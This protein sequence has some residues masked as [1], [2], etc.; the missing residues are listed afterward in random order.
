MSAYQ[1]VQ[2]VMGRTALAAVLAAS[3]VPA[4][5]GPAWGA[6]T[7]SVSAEGAPVSPTADVPSAETLIAEGYT[8]FQNTPIYWKRASTK[9]NIFAV[10]PCAVP[11]NF[12]GAN[13]LQNKLIYDIY[14]GGSATAIGAKAFSQMSSVQ[15]VTIDAPVT[16]LGEEAFSYSAKLTTV[17]LPDTLKSIGANAFTRCTALTGIQVPDGVTTIGESAFS[18]MTALSSIALPSSVTSLGKAVF[19]GDQALRTVDLGATGLTELPASLFYQCKALNTVA[20]PPALRTVG[21]AAFY[22]CAALGTLTLP[23][24]VT[25]IDDSAFNGCEGLASLS[26]TAE[27]AFN[28]PPHLQ[29]LGAY[30]FSGCNAV[31]DVVLPASLES[32]GIGVF[33][34]GAGISAGAGTLGPTQVDLSATRLTEVPNFTFQGCQLTSV[35]LPETVT[36]VGDYAFMMCK[37][38]PRIDLP[39]G[40]S[41]IGVGAFK[42]C[43]K[44]GAI[45]LPAAVTSIGTEAFS[46]CAEL[47]KLTLPAALQTL[48]SGAFAGCSGLQSVQ[49]GDEPGVHGVGD[50]TAVAQLLGNV[51]AGVSA[52]VVA[53]SAHEAAEAAEGDGAACAVC[54][55]PLGT[56]TIK[57]EELLPASS[58]SA[59]KT[60]LAQVRG[61][62]TKVGCT[63]RKAFVLQEGLAQ[64]ATKYLK[65]GVVLDHAVD[66]VLSVPEAEGEL[67]LMLADGTFADDDALEMAPDGATAVLRTAYVGPVA[68]V[69]E[70]IDPDAYDDP[71]VPEPIVPE[72]EAPVAPVVPAPPA[73]PAAPAKPAAPTA[74]A[75]PAAPAPVS[76]AR[77]KVTLSATSKTYTGKALKPSV[78]VTYGGKTLKAGTDYTLT[79]ASNKAI[80]KA[81]ITVKGKGAYTGTVKKTFKIVP[82]KVAAKKAVSTKKKRA[83]VTWAKGAAAQK[84][85]GYQV[86][87]STS[88]KFTAKTT[89]TK[90]VKGRTKTSCTLTGLK[91]GKTYYVQV[92]AYKTVGGV[93]YVGAWSSKVL[94]VKVR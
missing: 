73:T 52:E 69:T 32:M 17:A 85:T 44:L 84:L 19:Y 53:P 75:K 27:H 46:G 31:R 89:K 9:L 57:A 90:T 43:A 15:S 56:V 6:E 40:V 50:A 10:S 91:S 37:V 59:V 93:K 30:A 65:S 16:S 11:D 4:G 62:A 36:A 18:Q 83:T 35:K 82:K 3:L 28:L 38:L 7:P 71:V 8:Q 94:K 72:P 76:L 42:G 78:K 2:K 79:Y 39:A 81:T 68:W 87:Y 24:T 47:P 58:D 54:G 80:G 88:K 13:N 49:T 45:D 34:M 64:D 86:R 66:W 60:S 41:S 29:R 67:H 21:A 23:D 20:L 48:G 61:T 74:P 33:D 51:F 55:R 12:M 26:P 1:S 22:G 70:G 63:V 14:V 92:R 77:A 25:T 5:A